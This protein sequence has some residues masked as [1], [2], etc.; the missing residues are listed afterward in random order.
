MQIDY[1]LDY[2]RL[3]QVLDEAQRTNGWLIFFTHDVSPSPSAYGAPTDLIE[4][5]A[6]TAVDMGAVLAA[7]TLGAVLCG[8]MD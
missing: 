5:L 6:K 3:E 4:E 1:R 7:P 2:P 8:V